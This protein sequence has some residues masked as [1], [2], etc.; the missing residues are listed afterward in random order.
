M[1]SGVTLLE[2]LLAIAV[3]GLLMSLVGLSLRDRR[4]NGPAVDEMRRA[5]HR[6]ARERVEVLFAANQDTVLFLP[7]GRA[8]P[9][10]HARRAIATLSS[11]QQ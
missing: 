11:A 3:A 4:A 2:L 5:M 9:N 7:D 6:A 10:V 8:I 1:R